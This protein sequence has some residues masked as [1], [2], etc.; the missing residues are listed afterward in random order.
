MLLTL[1]KNS[2]IPASPSSSSAAETVTV[3]GSSQL[4]CVKVNWSG[5]VKSSVI[6]V[7]SASPPSL[8]DTVIVTSS[9]GSVLSV[10]V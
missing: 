2:V 4:S 3:C 7:R 8:G 10:T 1:C 9:V 5:K 6:A